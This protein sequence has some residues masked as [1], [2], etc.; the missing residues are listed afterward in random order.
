MGEVTRFENHRHYVAYSGYFAGLQKSQTI[1]RARMSRRGNRQ[2]K[3]ALF[4]NVARQRRA[5]GR[6]ISAVILQGQ[7][8]LRGASPEAIPSRR[9]R[10]IAS[11]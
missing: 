6:M 2:F 1:D 4:Q 9:A 10:E 8:S 5:R 7:R 11:R 3:R